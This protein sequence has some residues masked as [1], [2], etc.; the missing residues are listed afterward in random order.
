MDSLRKYA[1]LLFL[2]LGFFLRGQEYETILWSRDYRLSWSDFKG[3]VPDSPR[4]AATT[5]SGISYEF[6]TVSNKKGKY[7]LDYTVSTFFYPNKSWY[8]PKLCDE[9]ILGHEQLHFDI[10]E[11][12][13]RK[14]R[15][16][17]D[18]ASFTENVK[19]E[20]KA[21]YR[22]INEELAAFQQM[23]DRETNFSRD[24]E[25]Q[26]E[27]NEKIAKALRPQY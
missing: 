6:S 7:E 24:R 19:N 12:F 23:Y 25:K 14:M 4:A 2:C 8:Q 9:V 16:L 20:V 13:A 1:F 26:A 21:I 11:L 5:A 17:M 10:S 3:K 15:R 27:W 18:E 22:K